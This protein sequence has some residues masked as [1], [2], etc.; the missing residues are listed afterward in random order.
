MKI[1]IGEN[2][3]RLRREKN[4]TQE[5]LAEILGVS[6]AA[7]SKWER[8]DT[9]PDITLI[10]PLADFFGISVDE[11]LGYNSARAEAEIEEIFRQH[12]VLFCADKTEEMIDLMRKAK[13]DYPNNYRILMQYVWDV[14]GGLADNDPAVLLA[15]REELSALCDRVL[16]G[17]PDFRLR[18]EALN[19]KAKLLHADGKTEEA[20]AIYRDN[21]SNWYNTVGQKSEQLFAKDTSAFREQLICNMIDLANFAANKKIKEIWYCKGFSIDEKAQAGLRLGEALSEIREKYG[22]TELCL[23]ER[24]VLSDHV[25]KMT[26]FGAKISD[27]AAGLDKLFAAAACCDA[28]AAADE[29]VRRRLCTD[30]DGHVREFLK[31]RVKF[32]TE[33]D[34]PK[35]AAL[36]D[37]PECAAVLARWRAKL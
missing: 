21:F 13:K 1:Y 17:C 3:K 2:I 35:H 18:L 24:D 27:I 16:D 37:D 7:V 10:F 34:Y 30:A 4:I 28:F 12:N 31:E 23:V 20:L 25:W 32:Y 26:S 6:C 22:Y 14:G 19:M 5:T 9:Y 8:G 11:L 36:R 29:A 33:T 15:H